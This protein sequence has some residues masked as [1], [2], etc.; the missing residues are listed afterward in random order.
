MKLLKI[1][2]VVILLI[3]ILYFTYSYL[4]DKKEA[5]KTEEKQAIQT[6]VANL[7][8]KDVVISSTTDLT[9]AMA[10]PFHKISYE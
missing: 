9:G 3:V 6:T 7:G 2:G 8:G 10:R 1:T 5:K 4:F